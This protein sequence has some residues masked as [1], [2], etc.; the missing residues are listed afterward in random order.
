MDPAYVVQCLEFYN[1]AMATR[2][3]YKKRVDDASSSF[4]EGFST[5]ERPNPTSTY[6][7]KFMWEESGELLASFVE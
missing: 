5:L 4:L 7:S 1:Q 3:P 2:T 6:Q